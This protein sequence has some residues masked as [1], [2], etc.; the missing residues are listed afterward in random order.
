VLSFRRSFIRNLLIVSTWGGLVTLTMPIG[1]HSQRRSRKDSSQSRYE[2]L[3]R[4]RATS[5]FVASPS[6]SY[7]TSEVF[8]KGWSYATEKLLR[9][10]VPQSLLEEVFS[11]NEIP[12][13]EFVPFSL[14]PKEIS[15]S[16][17]LF[18]SRQKIDFLTEKLLLHQNA[19][20]SAFRRFGVPPEVVGAI[21]TVE[22]QFGKFTG[23]DLVVYRLLRLVSTNDPI[24][25][26][27]NYERL[28]AD[29]P[30]VSEREVSERGRYLE[31]TFYPQLKAFFSMCEQHNI[32]PLEVRGSPAGAFGLAQFMPKSFLM[33]AVDGNKNGRTSLFEI[34]D[35][36]FSIANFLS[37]E[38]WQ[39]QNTLTQQ[40][41]ALWAYNKSDAY[42][43]AIL[44]LARE[45]RKEISLS[46]D[47]NEVRRS[48][49][50]REPFHELDD[51]FKELNELP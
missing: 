37:K 28:R 38:G 2:L 30:Q 51:G 8:D 43:D 9:D 50:M 45:S 29:N 26:V 35:A 47:V 14:S 25:I 4:S 48:E 18:R 44:Y 3:S 12:S 17:R 39:A 5:Q 41:K 7:T 6:D 20:I 24:N 10:G 16:Y 46:E 23:K 27:W 33:Y 40:R 21:L 19:F 1:C 22:S 34:E 36:I 49:S 31:S 13:H 11:S 42:I 32:P 15:H